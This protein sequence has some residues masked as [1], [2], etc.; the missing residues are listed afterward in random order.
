MGL[1]AARRCLQMVNGIACVHMVSSVSSGLSL[2]DLTCGLV[3]SLG[4]PASGVLA[5]IRTPVRSRAL[6]LL[7]QAAQVAVEVPVVD[8]SSA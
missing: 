8:W 7:E 2:C 4:V 3:D 1:A 6:W 5:S